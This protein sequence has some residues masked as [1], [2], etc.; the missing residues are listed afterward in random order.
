[1]RAQC[2]TKL[3]CTMAK[4][5]ISITAISIAAL[6]CAGCGN[7]NAPS[8]PGSTAAASAPTTVPRKMCGDQSTTDA[9]AR[10]VNGE[11][12]ALQIPTGQVS[13]QVRDVRTVKRDDSVNLLY[14][15][16]TFVAT[17]DPKVVEAFSAINAIGLPQD[18]AIMRAAT[19]SGGNISSQ[20]EYTV[21]PTDDGKTDHIRVSGYEPVVKV[22]AAA[23]LLGAF[24]PTNAAEHQP[25]V[26]Q[27]RDLS[28]SDRSRVETRDPSSN[29]RCI[30]RVISRTTAVQS[31][32]T[33]LERGEEWGP[34]TQV[35]VDQKHG[36]VSYCAHGDYCYDSYAIQ[37]FNCKIDANPST[38][39]ED[40]AIYDVR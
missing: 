20:L 37:V 1:M 35:R 23:S 28:S 40:E 38:V 3:R 33:V 36:T 19:L 22:L 25:R 4:R 9:V 31:P 18:K 26:V 30:A 13:L 24:T 5:P 10:M 29:T 34:L 2:K 14:C 8:A 7:P 21:Q 15:E 11:V 6:I 27:H 32:E 39:D 12:S 16:A 17:V